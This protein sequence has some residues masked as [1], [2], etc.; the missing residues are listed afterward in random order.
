MP[1]QSS[2]WQESAHAQCHIQVGPRA[3]SGIQHLHHHFLDRFCYAT[4]ECGETM[5]GARYNERLTGPTAAKPLKDSARLPLKTHRSR[6]TFVCT[7][8]SN[9]PYIYRNDLHPFKLTLIRVAHTFSQQLKYKKYNI[10]LDRRQYRIT[11]SAIAETCDRTL[12]VD[13][14]RDQSSTASSSS[15]SSS[16]P[17]SK[18]TDVQLRMRL[19]AYVACPL[20]VYPTTHPY[21]IKI[22]NS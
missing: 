14:R 21:K 2:L 19:N 12:S 22:E 4:H 11:G 3:V 15:N 16:S 17:S 7:P 20:M 18:P 9:I 13:N 6:P 5:P 8:T 1:N 10:G